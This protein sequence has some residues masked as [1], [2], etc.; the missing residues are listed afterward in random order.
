MKK[1]LFIFTFFPF[2]SLEKY[3][4]F[5]FKEKTKELNFKD[6]LYRIEYIS[7]I[8]IGTP[9]QKIPLYLKFSQYYFYICN[10]KNYRIYNKNISKSFKTKDEKEY[11]YPSV[12]FSKCIFA[13]ETFYFLKENNI[14]T[15]ENLPFILTGNKKYDIIYP[16]SLGLGSQGF[17][18]ENEYNLIDL[19]YERSE[20]N[21]KK[22]FISFINNTHGYLIIGC[23][24]EEYN[25]Y[26]LK[27]YKI[28]K[29]YSLIQTY[30]FDWVISC[31]IF[32]NNHLIKFNV[33]VNLDFN[34]QFFIFNEDLKQ[35]LD[36]NFFSQFF[37]KEICFFEE[38]N[39]KYLLYYCESDDFEKELINFPNISFFQK[40]LNYTFEIN[41]LDLFRKIE[42]KIYFNAIFDKYERHYNTFGKPIFL[43]YQIV[44]DLDKKMLSFYFKKN[45]NE[46]IQKIL[47]IIFLFIII[48]IMLFYFLYFKKYF[49]SRKYRKNEIIENFDYIPQ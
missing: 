10:D 22:F 35:Y 46:T 11:Y 30:K 18:S 12:D 34:V 38:I 33:D 28:E 31:D 27:D 6:N 21:K 26:I 32:I 36:L 25:N 7:N 37:E 42:N 8:L 1:S 29:T 20:I 16:S 19:L 43:Q 47:I 2:F 41:K 4:I 14:I 15:I 3:I 44:F 13:N 17:D 40:E 9:P 49:I 24:Y 23:D 5:P 39:N 48:I 45:N